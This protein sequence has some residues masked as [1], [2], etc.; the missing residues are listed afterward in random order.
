MKTTKLLA[1]AIAALL[2]AGVAEAQDTRSSYVVPKEHEA[3]FFIDAGVTS[4]F[5][6]LSTR[7]T[8]A[9]LSGTVNF[10]GIS[11]SFGL[12]LNTYNKI[13]GESGF[14]YGHKSKAV[15]GTDVSDVSERFTMIPMVF[16]YSVCFPLSQDG[17]WELRISPSIGAALIY[18]R[19]DYSSATA[20]YSGK[21]NDADLGLVYGVGAGVTYHLNKRLYVD[22]GL[23]YL[24]VGETSYN[25]GKLEAFN[26]VALSVAVGYKL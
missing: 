6:N 18:T 4:M 7:E 2:C 12:R 5:A 3:N 16:S 26:G 15:N 19:Y 22:A 17:T 24:R 21:N 9:D 13:Q 20:S 10:T 1:F 25:W 11:A 23:R 14:L 8:S